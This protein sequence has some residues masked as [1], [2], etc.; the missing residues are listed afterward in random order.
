MYIKYCKY[1]YTHEIREENNGKK[2]QTRKKRNR[3]KDGN[4]STRSKKEQPLQKQKQLWEQS[5]AI[6]ILLV[7][8]D[9]NISSI[10]R[11]SNISSNNN[12]PGTSF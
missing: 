10:S 8:T 4:T 6:S 5:I 9:C 2:I 12:I 7:G 3:I 11:G 1:K